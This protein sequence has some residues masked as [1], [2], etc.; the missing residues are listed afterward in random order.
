MD[1]EES[2]LTWS[3]TD[4]N[5]HA[6]TYV[7]ETPLGLKRLAGSNDTGEFSGFQSD[8]RGAMRQLVSVEREV[9]LIKELLD[10]VMMK[11]ELLVSENKEMKNRILKYNHIIETNKEM[12]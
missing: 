11:Y 5:R 9:R 12:K 2:T 8:S 6:G 10:S 7:L 4:V 3:T 1:R